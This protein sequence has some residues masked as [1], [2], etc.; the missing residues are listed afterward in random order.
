MEAKRVTGS[1]LALSL[2]RE[3]SDHRHFSA[4]PAA[5]QESRQPDCE[6]KACARRRLACL[7]YRL[8]PADALVPNPSIQVRLDSSCPASP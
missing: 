6:W 8:I 1:G 3:V 4:A 7:R 5:G 2:G